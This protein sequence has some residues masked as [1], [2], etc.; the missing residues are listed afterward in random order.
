M[1]CKDRKKQKNDPVR[2]RELEKT[3]TVH[4]QDG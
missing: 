2:S 3:M 1:M 4:L